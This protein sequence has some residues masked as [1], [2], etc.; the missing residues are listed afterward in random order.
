MTDSEIIKK[1]SEKII[2]LEDML[3]EYMSKNEKLKEEHKELLLVKADAELRALTH[4]Q[5]LKKIEDEIGKYQFD[6]VT[7]L[8]NKIKSI[9]MS[10]NSN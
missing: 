3:N 7:N 8:V 6:S 1:Q 4:A 10:E 5:K 2:K 9:L